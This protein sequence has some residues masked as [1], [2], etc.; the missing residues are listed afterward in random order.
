MHQ[1]GL[2]SSLHK[3]TS[4]I[5]VANPPTYRSYEHDRFR[6]GSCFVSDN[7]FASDRSLQ[8]TTIEALSAIWRMDEDFDPYQ[9]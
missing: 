9:R 8:K 2:P 3:I 6:N 1:G 5:A 7:G 4:L